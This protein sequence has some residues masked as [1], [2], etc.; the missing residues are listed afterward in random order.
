MHLTNPAASVSL[1]GFG[2][3]VV[4]KLLPCT[5]STRAAVELPLPQ[6]PTHRCKTPVLGQ[7]DV[8][9]KLAPPESQQITLSAGWSCKATA[10]RKPRS[11][12][13]SWVTTSTFKCNFSRT[14]ARYA[15]PLAAFRK[16]SVATAARS[17]DGTAYSSQTA[18]SS[19]RTSIPFA[20]TSSLKVPSSLLFQSI[21]KLTGISLP[22]CTLTTRS[23]ETSAT[24]NFVAP[25]PM[26]KAARRVTSPGSSAM[27]KRTRMQGSSLG[28]EYKGRQ[29]ET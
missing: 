11:A 26:S 15:A 24:T 22:K 18:R 29:A 1:A 6:V 20:R 7:M 17:A 23:P 8:I 14:S 19:R 13:T 5:C 4:L 12:S 28:W 16:T 25:D 10:V 3:G 27:A 21:A 9:W 2:V